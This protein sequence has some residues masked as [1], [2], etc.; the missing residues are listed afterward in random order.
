VLGFIGLTQVHLIAAEQVNLDSAAATD[1]AIAQL[2]EVL[3]H[4]GR[5][6]IA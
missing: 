4:S 1:T 6:A 2:N 5:E 3:P